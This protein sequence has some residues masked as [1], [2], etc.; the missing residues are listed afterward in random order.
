LNFINLR[1]RLSQQNDE[2]PVESPLVRAFFRYLLIVGLSFTFLFFLDWFIPTTE[3]TTGSFSIAYEAGWNRPNYNR[4]LTYQTTAPEPF[5]YTQNQRLKMS[6]Q[7]ATE[8]KNSKELSIEKTALLR[9]IIYVRTDNKETFS[10]L[11]ITYATTLF[12]IFCAGAFLSV[13]FEMVK[14][15][16]LFLGPVILLTN[17]W[18]IYW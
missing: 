16:M 3:T 7:A 18:V 1:L 13:W 2:N 8:I 5:L 14:Y 6:R 10:P 12:C 17:V 15:A 9:Y 4:R 11:N